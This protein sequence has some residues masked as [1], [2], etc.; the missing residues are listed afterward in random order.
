MSAHQNNLSQ[1]NSFRGWKWKNSGGNCC[2]M[3]CAHWR[4]YCVARADEE[5]LFKII[6]GLLEKEARRQSSQHF[7]FL[8]FRYRPY[9]RN[10]VHMY[11]RV[12]LFLLLFLR[13]SHAEPSLAQ[14]SFCWMWYGSYTVDV[15][16]LPQELWCV[17]SLWMTKIAFCVNKHTK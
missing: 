3:G 6:D 8:P 1:T 12:S 7:L 14:S 11:M 15:V 10:R 2:W 16:L 17:V 4:Q 5:A 13:I 9:R